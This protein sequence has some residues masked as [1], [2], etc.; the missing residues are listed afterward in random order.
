VS[1]QVDE[2]QEDLSV[3]RQ[4][5][6]QWVPWSQHTSQ[7]PGLRSTNASLQS[8]SVYYL[9]SLTPPLLAAILECVDLV[10]RR[11]SR[12]EVLH[13]F[14]RLLDLIVGAKM[15]AYLDILEV[16]AYHTPKARLPAVSLLTTFWPRA[17]G[18]AVVSKPLP[19]CSYLNC[20][21]IGTKA[22]LSKDPP[23]A[24]QFLPWR[25]VPQFGRLGFEGIS[26]HDCRSC[27]NPILDFGLLCPFCMCAVHFDC[28]DYPEGNHLIQYSLATDESIQ[29]VAMYRFS[30]VLS[31]R[32]NSDPGMIQNGHH[33]FR[34]VNL[35][36]LCL[37]F[38]CCKPLWGCAMQGLKCF[39]CFQF[40]HRSCLSSSANL[41]YCNSIRINSNH[42]TIDW[43]VLRRSCMDYYGDI[44]LLTKEE[45]QNRSYEEVSIFFATLW[46]QLQI[47]TSGVA[48]GSIIIMRRGRNAAHAKE[49][50]VDE[51]E[52]HRV[53]QWCE[54]FLSTDGLLLS[55]AMEEYLHENRLDRTC[56]SMMF[57]WP[58]LTYISTTIKSPYV[59]P[60]LSTGSTFDLLN[61][62]QTDTR[63]DQP[64][65][66]LTHPFEAVSL[67]H[68]RDVLGHELFIHSDVA[69]R[70]ILSH[71]HQHGFFDRLDLNINLFDA[72]AQ[73]KHAY[74]TFPL[75]LGLDLSTDV[76]IL[77]SAVEACLSDL[78]LS[79]NEFG[80]LLLVRKLWPNGLASEYALRR[81]TRDILCWILA[82]VLVLQY[83]RT[84]SHFITGRKSGHYPP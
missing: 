20:L 42:M 16:V 17:V 30:T 26:Q 31:N 10:P 74:C 63:T 27:S 71:M 70:L 11:D 51:F 15:D 79:V 3:E 75:P 53:T 25:F 61:A 47:M 80:F 83:P 73:D 41:H 78:D 5:Q 82:E 58:T 33:L 49:H 67:S 1:I 76:E 46:T 68:M 72:D 19:I 29:K 7:D 18:H 55:A 32:L 64:L 65:E 40:V 8:L 60:K 48:L 54:A 38:I 52:L 57:D 43:T 34:T 62:S 6:P 4:G 9:A 66:V 35:F 81:L 21:N 69:A 37:C 50:R 44:L 36:T 22:G 28:Y 59:L 14:Y 39:S 84:S 45:L 12:V 23:Y 13:R 77:V 24:H 56:Y 2:A